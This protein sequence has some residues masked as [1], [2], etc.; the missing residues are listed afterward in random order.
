M[1]IAYYAVNAKFSLKRKLISL[2]LASIPT[3]SF[4]KRIELLLHSVY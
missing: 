2:L 4:N 3:K 1:I